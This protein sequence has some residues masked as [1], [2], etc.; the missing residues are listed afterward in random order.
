MDFKIKLGPLYIMIDREMARHGEG[1]NAE[2]A[3]R[4]EAEDVEHQDKHE[5]REDVRRIFPSFGAD[6][7]VHHARDEA[8][9]AFDGDLPT[10]RNELTLHATEHEHPKQQT[11]NDRS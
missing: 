11:G 2:Q 1:V 9:K 4:R 6:I 5:E 10:A 8:G 7:G 3:E